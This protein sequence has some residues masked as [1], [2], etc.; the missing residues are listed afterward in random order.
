MSNNFT[1][2]IAGASILIT[3]VGLLSRGFGFLREVI[4]AAYFGLGSDFEIYLI[5]AVFPV[6]INSVLLYLGQNYYIP[7][8]SQIKEEGYQRQKELFNKVVILFFTGALILTLV[9]FFLSDHILDIY[10]KGSQTVKIKTALV[11]FRIFIFTIPINAVVSVISAHLQSQKQFSGPAYSQLFANISVIILVP[12]LSKSIGT[13]II[14][15]A[16]LVGSLLQMIFLVKKVNKYLIFNF[17]TIFQNIYFAKN[18]FITS[19]LLLIIITEFISQF[20]FIIDRYFYTDVEPGGIAALNYALTIYYLPIAILSVALSTAIFPSFSEQL[21]Q[22][23]RQIFVKKVNDSISINSFLFTPIFLIFFVYG[24]YVI[25][26]IFQR[27]NFS[28]L[29]TQM[30][31]SAL[32][33]FSL[34][35]IFYSIFSIFNKIFYGAGLI[36][37]LLIISLIGGLIKFIF[38]IVLVISMKHDGLALSSSISYIFLCLSALFVIIKKLNIQL[39]VY[40]WKCVSLYFS[41]SLLS[42]IITFIIL[43]SLHFNFASISSLGIIIFLSIYIFNTIWIKDYSTS[44]VKDV[45]V[46]YRSS[47]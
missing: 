22:N 37:E 19:S 40:F 32:Q 25:R 43:E 24:D 7:I 10:L 44:L 16:Y 3:I 26:L 4:F 34:S 41:N 21:K 31:F 18:N 1:S 2:T 6:T 47:L 29:D 9:L 12:L 8:Y 5:A 27:G 28:A 46:S 42:Y 45:W 23:D 38:N 15:I 36:K 20:Y 39:H 11:I 17:K 35:L 13:T 33:Y 30:T 14:P